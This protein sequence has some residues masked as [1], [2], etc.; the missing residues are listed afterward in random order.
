MVR[1]PAGNKAGFGA[2]SGIDSGDNVAKAIHAGATH[3]LPKPYTT[4]ILL[5]LVREVIEQPAITPG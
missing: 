5:K 4:E 2:A 1:T 3:F